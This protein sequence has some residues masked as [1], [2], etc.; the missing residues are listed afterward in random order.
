MENKT[1]TLQLKPIGTNKKPTL[2]LA[3]NKKNKTIYQNSSEFSDEEI[4][5]VY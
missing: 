2:S 3:S 4:P 5:F 1:F